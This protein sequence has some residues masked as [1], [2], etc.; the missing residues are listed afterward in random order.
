MQPGGTLF[1]IKLESSS[2]LLRW[3]FYIE[4]S[5]TVLVAIVA[6]F[7]LPDFP[8]TSSSWLSPL[9]SRL[10]L[11]RM[12]EDCAGIG[13]Q[14]E[15]EQGHTAGFVSAMT[16]WKVIWLAL[17]L[18]SIVVSLSFN[19]F[20]PTLSATMGYNRTITLLLCAPPWIFAT[21]VAFAVTRSVL[22]KS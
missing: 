9:E 6:I 21:L 15:T 14:G 17:A 5:L 13:D 7:I 8:A 22:R 12:E 11:K 3:L 1:T 19:A 18:T 4:G 10:A 16:D 20:F 2:P